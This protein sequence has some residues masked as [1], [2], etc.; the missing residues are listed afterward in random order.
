MC[1]VMI[2][3]LLLVLLQKELSLFQL[4]CKIFKASLTISIGQVAFFSMKI[5]ANNFSLYV[6]I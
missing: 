5:W 6:Q 4:A 1:I 3:F 2:F